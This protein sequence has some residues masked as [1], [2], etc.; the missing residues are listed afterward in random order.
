MPVQVSDLTQYYTAEAA[1]SAGV[2]RDTLL[3]YLRLK[4]IDDSK[5]QRDKHDRRLWTEEHIAEIR[6]IRAQQARKKKMRG[7][8]L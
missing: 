4:L 5:I 7:K 6:K 8:P 1:E 2:S 3:R